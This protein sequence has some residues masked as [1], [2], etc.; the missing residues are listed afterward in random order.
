MDS[1]LGRAG[2]HIAFYITF[3]S[4]MLLFFLPSGSPEQMITIFT[5]GIGLL[6][7]VLVTF[8]VRLGQ[9]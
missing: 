6:F 5:F 9:R 2:F 4:G 1:Q 7:L 8:L 3:V